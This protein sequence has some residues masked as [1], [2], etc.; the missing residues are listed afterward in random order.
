MKLR[1]NWRFHS[2]D[3]PVWTQSDPTLMIDP[4][5]PSCGQVRTVT[6]S[7]FASTVPRKVMLDRV[8]NRPPLVLGAMVNVPAV[9]VSLTLS[10]A[11]LPTFFFLAGTGAYLSLG[12][13]KTV[14][15]LSLF[16]V[17]RGL[18]LVVYSPRSAR[19]SA[20]AIH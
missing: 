9:R 1:A 20:C 8:R 4:L 19:R 16:F 12:R 17:T 7:P 3:S 11:L 13:K 14:Q 18:G 5:R 15:Q 2:S 10:V 6:G